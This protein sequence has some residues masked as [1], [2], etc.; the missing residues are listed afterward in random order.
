MDR[1]L[2]RGAYAKTD[3]AAVVPP[4]GIRAKLGWNRLIGIDEN[5]T[6]SDKW[7]AGG[8]F[9]WSLLLFIT[10]LIGTLWNYIDPW[11]TATWSAFWHVIGIGIPVLFALATGL[12]F[13]YGGIRDMRRLFLRLKHHRTHDRDDGTV[14]NHHNLDETAAS[15]PAPVRPAE[16][17]ANRQP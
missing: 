13:T 2:H 9:Y 14:L 10:F 1:M 5:F 15:K 17:P 6:R 11:S 8:I 3:P 7:I 16:I 12:W 4:A